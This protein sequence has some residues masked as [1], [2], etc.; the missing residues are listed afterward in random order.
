MFL[1]RLGKEGYYILPNNKNFWPENWDLPE[2]KC[3]YDFLTSPSNFQVESPVLLS[4][5]TWTSRM[6]FPLSCLIWTSPK[7]TGWTSTVRSPLL[8][9]SSI[10]S[11]WEGS[12]TYFL[13]CETWNTE[14]RLAKGGGRA[15]SY[16]TSPILLRI[17]YG[18][19][20]LGDNF[21]ERVALPTPVVGVI[22]KKT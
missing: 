9:R 3:G 16:A 20:N 22:L 18:P 10:S 2:N 15:I 11:T 19:M 12:G 4:Q 5:M 1:G 8:C 7:P 13:S 14:W 6:D 17:W 21:F